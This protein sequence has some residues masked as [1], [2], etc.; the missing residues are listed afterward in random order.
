MTT[1]CQYIKAH[2]EDQ[3]NK[4]YHDSE[5]GFPIK[6]DKVLFERLVFEINQAGLSWITILKKAEN[7][8][9]AYDGFDIARIAAYNGRDRQRLLGDPGIIRNRLKI[10]AAMENAKR[11]IALR[12]EYGSFAG[13]LDAHHPASL[14][15]WTKLFKQTFVFTGG[16]I[17]R[18]FLI[19]TGYLKGAH[20][21]G[22][23]IFKRVT[24]LKPR[25]MDGG[26]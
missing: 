11:I 17:V 20:R 15:A 9:H 22:C 21:P 4:R 26:K 5:Y 12:A 13:W 2:P 23:P 19:S 25:W 18:E 10:N 6:D 24:E 7:F 16:E 8:R 1:Y 3:Y 14:K